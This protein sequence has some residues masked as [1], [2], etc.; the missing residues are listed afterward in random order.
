MIANLSPVGWTHIQCTAENAQVEYGARFVVDHSSRIS[1]Q[2]S[3]IV[4]RDRCLSGAAK[5][6]LS[7]NQLALK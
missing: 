7:T 3:P 4:L 6:S 5:I 1:Q 2:R